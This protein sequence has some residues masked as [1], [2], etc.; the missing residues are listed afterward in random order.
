MY[1]IIH[2]TVFVEISYG[3]LSLNVAENYECPLHWSTIKPSLHN[4]INRLSMPPINHF[5]DAAEA[6]YGR[7]PQ[8]II[9][10]F[11]FSATMNH[12]KA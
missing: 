8:N 7:L 6:W 11:W 9:G 5:T 12:N 1:S 10:Q 4:V 2:I 3:R